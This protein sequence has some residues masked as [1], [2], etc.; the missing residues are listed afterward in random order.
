MKRFAQTLLILLGTISPL[1]AITDFSKLTSILN[2]NTGR[3]D[4]IN[5]TSSISIGMLF[6][7][8]TRAATDGQVLTFTQWA[9]SGSWIPKTPT[10]GQGG[11]GGG[12][13]WIATTAVRYNVSA[14]TIVFT[15]SL[16]A[17]GLSNGSGVSTITVELPVSFSS[18][19]T[20][21]DA[22]RLS[23]STSGTIV[24]NLTLS[25]GSFRN[26]YE[27]FHVTASAFGA[28][29][30]GTQT[31]TGTNY[32]IG[33]TSI[34]NTV[35]I[36]SCIVINSSWSYKDIPLVVS[37]GRNGHAGGASIPTAPNI[38]L[39]VEGST[40]VATSGRGMIVLK[41]P[42]E[43]A[44]LNI[45]PSNTS[46]LGTRNSAALAFG[47][48]NNSNMIFTTATA[49]LPGGA[50][51]FIGSGQPVGI[52]IAA[53]QRPAALLDVRGGSISVTGAGSDIGVGGVN[54]TVFMSSNDLEHTNFK[55]TLSTVSTKIDGLL[56]SF[57]TSGTLMSG[58]LTALSTTS[59]RIDALQT[60]LST[61]GTLMSGVLTALSSASVAIDF[62]KV[63][64][65]TTD[66]RINSQF[67]AIFSSLTTLSNSTSTLGVPMVGYDEGG[68]LGGAV[69]AINFV[70]SAVGAT[71]SGS[72][73]TV[74]VTAS[75][76]GSGG[77]GVWVSTTAFRY[78]VSATTIVFIG[79]LVS[80]GAFNGSGV[81]TITIEFPV[82][83]STIAT[84]IDALRLSLSTSGTLMSGV[85]TSL[86]TTSVAID[87]LNLEVSSN[88]ATNRSQFT[89]TF[90]SISTLS[91]SVSSNNV[92][93]TSQFIAA[94]SSIA[95]LSTSLS[96]NNVTNG[97]QFTAVFSSIT[98]GIY[99]T[100]H[101][102]TASQVFQSTVT[103]SSSTIGIGNITI[104]FPSS[105][106][107]TGD[108]ILH[109]NWGSSIAYFGGDASGGSSGG[110]AP[111]LQ[112]PATGPYNLNN[113]AIIVS[114]GLMIGTT[115]YGLISIS[116]VN[117]SGFA[118]TITTGTPGTADDL[119]TLSRSTYTINIPTSTFLGVLQV[120][121]P[122]NG[123]LLSVSSQTGTSP[124]FYNFMVSSN[125]VVS[126]GGAVPLLTSCGSGP[127][128]TGDNFAGTVTGGATSSGCTLTFGTQF[129][130]DP[131][132]VVTPQT[133][134]IANTFTYTHSKTGIV[135]T[136]TAFGTGIF[137]YVCIGERETQ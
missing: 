15:G 98:V 57:S 74:T 105:A 70:G 2:P 37:F 95:T 104:F 41:N 19:A 40:E 50:I 3:P 111:S 59:S 43:G 10:G 109:Y 85:L 125:G 28:M 123:P 116:S 44:E 80:S 69:T 34:T 8:S 137:D 92:T 84:S 4:Y 26:E 12:G 25:T 63:Q 83:F 23:M 114:S 132:C 61:S 86:S 22:L 91:T 21:I 78:N 124:S 51:S 79:S 82:T 75:G 76:G 13:V 52:G 73:L 112:S 47:T 32:F 38:A 1:N 103:F 96:S 60:A 131:H 118:L 14:T 110:S 20:S 7:V 46:Y 115:Q 128:I 101:T 127:S 99:N 113:N 97:T 29:I 66:A 45:Y 94:F 126:T 55:T 120:Y 68:A 17:S 90:S 106:P 81:S 48:N 121:A 87:F 27:V 56:T 134:S 65:S 89:A 102:W 16:I 54:F 108:S 130:N 129:K 39:L 9:T 31:W 117:L 71:L 58:V 93:N 119:M 6:D 77:G 100:T 122:L 35:Y 62:L 64:N 11:G 42:V 136:E 53:S 33:Q 133:G 24:Q 49:T 72:T 30:N 5:N 88:N 135:V 36:T 107:A 18:Y 67:T